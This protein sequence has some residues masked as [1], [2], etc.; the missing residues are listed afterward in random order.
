LYHFRISTMPGLQHHH[1]HPIT[2]N[3]CCIW[4]NKSLLYFN[5]I[6]A[7]ATTESSAITD[8]P[9][10]QQKKSPRARRS[11][12][13]YLVFWPMCIRTCACTEFFWAHL[14]AAQCGLTH[15]LFA[16]IITDET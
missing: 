6:R 15:E 9:V 3:L 11:R 5:V 8:D 2:Y 10:F 16:A 4:V 7:N 1:L 14:D 12:A 13:L